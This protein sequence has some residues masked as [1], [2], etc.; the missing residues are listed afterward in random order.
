MTGH[1]IDHLAFEI[2]ASS[3]KEANRACKTLEDQFLGLQSAIE[4]ALDQFYQS[5]QIITLDRLDVDLGTLHPQFV[6]IE[7]TLIMALSTTLSKS[8]IGSSGPFDA[9]T[10]AIVGEAAAKPLIDILTDFLRNGFLTQPNPASALAQVLKSIDHLSNSDFRSLVLALA[11][12]LISR[13]AALR[14]IR[15]FSSGLLAR[16]MVT[17]LDARTPWGPIDPPQLAHPQTPLA[18]Q[19][20]PDA[21]LIIAELC[22]PEPKSQSLELITKFFAELSSD[23]KAVPGKTRARTGRRGDDLSEQNAN[24]KLDTPPLKDEGVDPKIIGKSLPVTAA[25][26]VLLHPYLTTLFGRLDL[27]RKNGSFRS[28]TTQ[29]FASQIIFYLATG[30]INTPEPDMVLPKILCGLPMD[31][32]TPTAM[33]LTGDQIEACNELLSAVIEHWSAIGNTSPDGLRASFLQREGLLRQH[34]D[35]R[36]LIV[37]TSSIDMLLTK[38]PWTLSIVKTPFMTDILSVDWR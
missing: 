6:G 37:E 15:H 33:E 11:P 38:L 17:L 5:D 13:N 29:E 3:T 32:P 34:K 16:I 36:Q 30:D 22:G 18:A 14:L 4:Q 23:T 1:R 25:G 21:T 12:T 20:A 7:D 35:R 9:N 24:A 19:Y 28:L 10:D 26:A 2:Q 8:Q 27:L 31:H